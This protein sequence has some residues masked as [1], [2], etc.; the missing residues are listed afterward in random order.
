MSPQ[1][2]KKKVWTQN[3]VADKDKDGNKEYKEE[4]DEAEVEEAEEYYPEFTLEEPEVGSEEEFN[5][6]EVAEAAEEREALKGWNE[7]E[8]EVDESI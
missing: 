7:E 6:E 4:A 1:A 2:G 3:P 5:K 8:A